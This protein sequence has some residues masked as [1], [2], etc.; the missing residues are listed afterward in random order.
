[1]DENLIRVEGHV[2]GVGFR[3]FCRSEAVGLQLTG[4]ARN[5]HDG[6]VEVLVQGDQAAID[7]LIERLREGPRM[8][9]VHDVAVFKRTPGTPFVSF[10][11]Q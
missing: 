8:A 4:F 9:A 3:E 2:Q 6:R 5:L 1:M 11:V 7:I 10:E